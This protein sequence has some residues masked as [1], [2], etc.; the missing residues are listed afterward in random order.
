MTIYKFSN[1]EQAF[2]LRKRHG[3]HPN[4]QFQL[5]P[6][7]SGKVPYHLNLEDIL[8]AARMDAIKKNGKLVFHTTGDTGGVK[9]GTSQAIVAQHMVADLHGSQG[10]DVPAFFYHLGD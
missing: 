8:P 5:L 6:K 3:I 2:R 7:P 9:S 1:T 4:Q 10:A